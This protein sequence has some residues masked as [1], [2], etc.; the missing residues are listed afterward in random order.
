MKLQKLA[1]KLAYRGFYKLAQQLD[2]A[3]VQG[4]SVQV[5]P[6]LGAQ[7]QDAVNELKKA[8]PNIFKGIG[9][10]TVLTGGPFGMVTSKDPSTVQINLNKIKQEVQKQMGGTY[11]PSNPEHKKAFDE[12][13]KRSIVETVSHEAAH[14]K[15]FNPETGKFPGGEGVAE[16]AERSMMQKMYQGKPIEMNANKE[17]RWQIFKKGVKSCAQKYSSSKIDSDY[18]FDQLK[19]G[20][21]SMRKYDFDLDNFDDFVQ[22]V[23]LLSKELK[24]S[25]DTIDIDHVKDLFSEA[26]H[27]K[28]WA[29]KDLDSVFSQHR[30]AK[31][32]IEFYDE[33]MSDPIKLDK[34]YTNKSQLSYFQQKALY[35][36]LLHGQSVNLVPHLLV[37]DP[38]WRALGEKI[39]KQI[40][41][42]KNSQVDGGLLKTAVL[43]QKVN[44]NTGNKEWA[45][46]SKKDHD[47]VLQWYG[48]KK[49]SKE[50]IEKT[51][52]RVQYF[53]H[54]KAQTGIE[55]SGSQL[56]GH[57]DYSITGNDYLAGGPSAEPKETRLQML[58]RKHKD[59]LKN[60]TAGLYY[61]KENNGIPVE[62]DW[63]DQ[64]K[65]FHRTNGP[66]ADDYS[67]TVGWFV[68]GKLHR[69]DGPA[70]TDQ[71]N[72][73][74]QYWVGGHQLNKEVF[75]AILGAKNKKDLAHYLLS[76]NSGER[77][78]AGYV[79]KKLQ[80]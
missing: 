3:F 55:P 19:R 20:A 57:D 32:L 15:D 74:E 56:A 63:V 69:L 36:A 45:L 75:Y 46:V 60:R 67:G 66:A 2:E 14:T 40:E 29:Q 27:S 61:Y 33:I 16:S 64:T 8:D 31:K 35:Q 4:P 10:I 7:V 73:T 24:K 5:D 65:T 53:K 43:I 51:E 54:K 22:K 18:Y 72:E 52:K 9:K 77:M 50:R 42:E 78:L 30:D 13:V 70:H 38:I 68:D 23:D 71:K 1:A 80:G 12:A 59:K 17:F 44:K 34:A 48:Q 39:S 62:S 47:K 49:P 25:I 37:D 6:A 11:S 21:V 58:Y 26:N 76:P 28:D 79:S 41:I